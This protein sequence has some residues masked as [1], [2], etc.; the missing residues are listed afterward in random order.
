MKASRAWGGVFFIVLGLL[1]LLDSMEV[2]E[3][4]EIVRTYWPLVLIYFGIRAIAG[5]SRPDREHAFPGADASGDYHISSET[6]HQSAV[7]GNLD[8][9]I[10]S[11][12]FAGGSA[13]TV[14]GELD[15]DLS[16]A[17]FREGRSFLKLSSVFGNTRVTLP[18]GVDYAVSLKTGIGSVRA[19]ERREGGFG[20]GLLYQTPGYEQSSRTLMITASQ[21]LGDIT[22]RSI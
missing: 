12:D 19:D 10:D 5:R 16:A 20:P 2:I 8:C 4:G 14:F 7:F 11:R 21:V 22:V 6:M 3:F 13:S 17:T 15:I 1:F 9:R 18:R